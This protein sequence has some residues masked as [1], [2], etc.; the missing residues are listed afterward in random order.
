VAAVAGLLADAGIAAVLGTAPEKEKA[1]GH[2][3]GLSAAPK[4]RS[5]KP[6]LARPPVRPKKQA[7]WQV[8]DAVLQLVRCT[9]VVVTG[10]P[11]FAAGHNPPTSVFRRVL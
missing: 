3:V 1:D 5:V 11:Q 7:P 2:A 6:P 4:P 9:A 10:V 8:A